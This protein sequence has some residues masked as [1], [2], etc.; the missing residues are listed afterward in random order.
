MCFRQCPSYFIY[1][2]E[3]GEIVYHGE[4]PVHRKG[5]KKKK[6]NPALFQSIMTNLKKNSFDTLAP[7]Y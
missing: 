5:L 2:I 4:G 6:A 3:D 7:R 1:V